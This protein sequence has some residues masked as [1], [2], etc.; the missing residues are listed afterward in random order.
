LRSEFAPLKTA[1][2]APGN[3]RA[4]SNS[5]VGRETE[6]AQLTEAIKAYQLVTL[7]GV[8]GVGKTRLAFEVGGRLADSF[9][10]GVW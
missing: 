10:D 3:L 4:R 2:P 5:F 8:G 9:A 6:L 1:D 7:T